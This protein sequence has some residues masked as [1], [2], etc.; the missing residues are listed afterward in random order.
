MKKIQI[1]A[2][3]IFD[4]GRVVERHPFKQAKHFFFA[5]NGLRF[6]YVTGDS[7][8]HDLF[9]IPKCRIDLKTIFTVR[10]PKTHT[11]T[12]WAVVRYAGPGGKARVRIRE[13]KTSWID[14]KGRRFNK[15][16]N[17][18]FSVDNQFKL[19]PETITQLD[20]SGAIPR[21]P[22]K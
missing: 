2:N 11:F 3:L 21:N 6:D 15:L 19:L 20:P 12:H 18:W 14:E 7:L 17:N 5:D 10:D 13:T 22:R 4:D 1:V 16:T 9:D 8:N